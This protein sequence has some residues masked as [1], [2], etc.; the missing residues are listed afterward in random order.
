MIFIKVSVYAD[1]IKM[2]VNF[3]KATLLKLEEHKWQMYMKSKR[4]TQKNPAQRI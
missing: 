3:S 2:V 4:A 1:L